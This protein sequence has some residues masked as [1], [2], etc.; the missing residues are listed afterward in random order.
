MDAEVAECDYVPTGWPKGSRT[1]HRRARVER[2]ELS[3]DTQSRTPYTIDPN[4]LV[5]LATGMKCFAFAYSFIIT[6]V[7]GDIVD[8]EAWWRM[9]AL[10]E[11]KINDSKLELALQRTP[12]GCGAVSAISMWAALLGLN[13]SSWLQVL[14]THDEGED[15]REHGKRLRRELF[16]VAARGTRHCRRTEIPTAPEHHSGGF[17]DVWHALDELPASSGP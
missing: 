6:D 4:Q 7:D 13:F 12:S 15:V 16:C 5:F 3:G 2:G 1:I 14:G 8:I 9:R 17:T 10:V 11:A